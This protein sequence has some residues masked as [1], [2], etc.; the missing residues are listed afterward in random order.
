MQTTVGWQLAFGLR[1]LSTAERHGPD[2]AHLP[3]SASTLSAAGATTTGLCERLDERN[4]DDHW[5]SLSRFCK[6]SI[7][8]QR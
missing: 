6:S 8:T 1:R 7:E 5:R 3:R 4:A 2:Q